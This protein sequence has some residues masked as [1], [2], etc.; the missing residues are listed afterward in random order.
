MI[1][2]HPE[3]DLTN[4]PIVLGAEILKEL[5]PNKCILVESLLVRMMKRNKKTTLNSFLEALSFLYMVDLVVVDS[6]KVSL[7][8]NES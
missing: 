5:R 6:F 3:S 2:P 1:L 7:V 8:R 4:N